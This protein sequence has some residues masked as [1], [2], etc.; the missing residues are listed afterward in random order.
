M[1]WYTGL[2]SDNKEIITIVGSSDLDITPLD[3]ETCLSLGFLC[4]KLSA[5][6]DVPFV[7]ADETNNCEC[8]DI[9]SIVDCAASKHFTYLLCLIFFN[10]IKNQESELGNVRHGTKYD[11]YI[12]NAVQTI[13]FLLIHPIHTQTNKMVQK[14]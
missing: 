4:V 1:L 11:K 7:D 9:S 13:L 10:S 8:V 2:E 5:T 3:L 12:K 6:T 14:R